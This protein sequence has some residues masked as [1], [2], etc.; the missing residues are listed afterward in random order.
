MALLHPGQ[1]AP[2]LCRPASSAL[3]LSAWAA[4]TVGVGLLSTVSLSAQEN[5]HA[6]PTTATADSLT[7]Q[8][9]TPAVPLLV[10]NPHGPALSITI[11]RPPSVDSQLTSVRIS[12][13]GTDDLADIA[14]LQLFSTGNKPEFS[15]ATPWGR[16]QSPAREVTFTETARLEAGPNQFWLSIRLADRANLDHRIA[17]SAVSI[18]T[19]QGEVKPTVLSAT[20]QRIGFAVRRHGDDGVHTHR[21]PALTIT[22]RGTL[23]CVYDLRRNEGRDLQ[24]DIDIGLSRSTDGGQTWESPRVIMDQGEYGG[25]PQSQNG[26]SDPGIVVD[27]Q[28]G[29]IFCFAVWMNGKPKKHQWTDDGSEP[30]FEIGKAAQFLMVRSRDDGLTWSAPENLTRTLKQPEWWLFA[31]APQSG[32]QM[33]DG[34]LVMPV[35]GRSGRGAKQTFATIMTSRDH[36]RTW[37]V[38]KPG[39]VGGNECQ[40]A[41]LDNGQIMLNVRNDL[42][43]FRAVSVTQDFGQTWQPHPTSGQAL[44]E[45][46]CNGSL[47]RVS[48]ETAG[49]GKFFLVFSNP[50]SQTARTH[51]TLQ[52]SV[53][54]GQT[55]P[56]THHI[57]LDEGRGAGY[58]SLTQISPTTVGLIYEGSQS[59]LVFQ[60]FSVAE[61]RS[62]PRP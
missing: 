61:L 37:T 42:A 3:H 44:I 11:Q 1:T 10:R 36:G 46:N 18:T 52:V 47:L 41:R 33:P 14:E 45:P 4:L 12:L 19:S 5:L 48:D 34:T 20:R 31:P 58:P 49:S 25:L 28:T 51:Q 35:Q 6:Q 24:E 40:A 21:I 43:R 50:H 2:A 38:G 7:V 29:E 56:A 27:H 39:Y 17:A 59:Q 22:P 32:F 16:P 9:R 26:C 30:G 55:W 60:R 15:T 23:L 8:T 54:A 53:D 57:L 62:G 13:A